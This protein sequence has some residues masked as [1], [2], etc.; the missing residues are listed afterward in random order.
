MLRQR[1]QT[2][3]VRIDD[4]AHMKSKNRQKYSLVTGIVAIAGEQVSIDWE[5]AQGGFL[6]DGNGNVL[7]WSAQRLLGCS[8][9]CDSIKLVMY[10][11]Y[12]SYTSIKRKVKTVHD[13]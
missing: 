10:A 9:M 1:S 5:G 2:Q 13:L 3:R 11:L 12:V 7:L 4:S 8:H 6:G